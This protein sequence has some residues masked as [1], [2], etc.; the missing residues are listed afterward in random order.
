MASFT[1]S[2]TAFIEVIP[3]LGDEHLPEI[4]A[5]EF[6]AERLDGDTPANPAPLVA[7]WGLMMRSLRKSAPVDSDGDDPLERALRE[8]GH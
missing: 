8:A 6:L 2:L 3:W 7:Q 4:T 5:L 1:E